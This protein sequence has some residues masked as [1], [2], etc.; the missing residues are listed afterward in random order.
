MLG[1]P[2]KV[3]VGQCILLPLLS[4][5]GPAYYTYGLALEAQFLTELLLWCVFGAYYPKLRFC[6]WQ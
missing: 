5:A 6:L 4:G 1:R 2:A 3:G